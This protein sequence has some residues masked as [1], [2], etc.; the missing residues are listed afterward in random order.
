MP[1]T[2]Y[3]ELNIRVSLIDRPW[4]ADSKYI[5]VMVAIPGGTAELA[6][7]GS[8]AEAIAQKSPHV[9][10]FDSKRISLGAD[11][12]HCGYATEIAAYLGVQQ[13]IR[14]IARLIKKFP[15]FCL[16]REQAHTDDELVELA[17]RL[18]DEY[19][20]FR[21]GELK[22]TDNER[23]ADVT[24]VHFGRDAGEDIAV[25]VRM[26]EGLPVVERRYRTLP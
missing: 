3:F 4:V 11:T 9:L 24:I 8:A 16:P 2:H 15:G 14:P 25:T 10:T 6:T 5:D 17:A 13:C 19:G 22:V 1:E 7:L 12:T 20:G 26:I 21:Y 18:L 23:L